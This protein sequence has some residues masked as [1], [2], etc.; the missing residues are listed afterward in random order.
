MYRRRPLTR[1]LPLLV[2]G[3]LVIL[4]AGVC[5][6]ADL[7]GT[8]QQLLA[9]GRPAEALA[10]LDT[11]LQ[12]EPRNAEAHAWRGNALGTLSDQAKDMMQA[13]QY[14]L[15]AL[16]EFET[17][18]QLDP[19]NVTGRL[20]RGVANLMAP[21]PFGNLDRALEDL[22]EVL[23]AEPRNAE[24]HYYLGLACTK[25]GDSTRARAAF[26]KAIELRP[27]HSAAVSA[28]AALETAA[29]G[30]A[31]PANI[32]APA[33]PRRPGAIR[34]VTAIDAEGGSRADWT[35]VFADGRIV[36]AGKSDQVQT[37]D[38][39]EVIDGTG[40]F[41]I[42]GLWDMHVHVLGDAGLYFP[43]YLAHGITGIREMHATVS[44]DRRREIAAA[45]ESGALCGPRVVAAGP[46]LD[47]PRSYWPGS[48]PVANAEEASHAVE[49][50]AQQHVAFLK[51]YSFLPRE[52]YLAIVAT[53]KQR[54]LPF[55][56]HVPLSV[57]AFEA[58]DLGQKSIEHLDGI[59]AAASKWAT[60]IAALRAAGDLAALTASEPFQHAIEDYDASKAAQL[61]A[62]YAAN[63]TW[64][65]PTLTV[66]RGVALRGDSAFANDA[67]KK[68]VPASIQEF[69]HWQPQ[70]A[71][72]EQAQ[73]RS[74]RGR[75][76]LQRCLEVVGQ[77]NRAGVPLLA[78][79]DSPYAYCFP[80]SGLHDELALLVEA[81]LSPREALQAATLGPAR[82]LGRT[83]ELGTIAAGKLADLVLLAADPLAD[84]HNTRRI[85]A[86]V[87]A[88]RVYPA[89]ALQAMLDA[90]AMAA[91]A[92][93][94]TG[95]PAAASAL[96]EDPTTP[97]SENPR[98]R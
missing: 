51:V 57:S 75:L 74:V 22:H 38:G 62:R 95:V 94:T 40:K 78:G 90:V 93:P 79:T 96:P 13:A 53:A 89:A 45:V 65:V 3:T 2:L 64:Q 76:H 10:L 7:L 28:L 17:A 73:Q 36:A 29:A 66:M 27:D 31:V 44:P 11:L 24:A 63:G 49:T 33:P 30:A 58:S 16:Q 82:Y 55:A 8:A 9:Q 85:V 48:I 42:P 21:P 52:A 71:T 87:A 77:M 20:G 80:G 59:F 43:L 46:I 23:E 86:V 32:A 41:L 92:G 67:R 35:V 84:I 15:G 69:F 61:F 97:G 47:G 39:M 54:D 26:Q 12:R 34:H 70:P 56:G 60:E 91:A 88:G 37:P 25:R 98:Q 6:A 81:G 4:H 18:I 5:Q 50:L 72:R 14:G 1:R 83:N 68:Y 19:N